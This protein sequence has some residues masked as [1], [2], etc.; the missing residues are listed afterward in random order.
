MARMKTFY[1][2]TLKKLNKAATEPS[3]KIPKYSTRDLNQ[4]H[5]QPPRVPV[6]KTLKSHT[7]LP[8]VTAHQ[9]LD[10]NELYQNRMKVRDYRVKSASV[11]TAGLAKK[12]KTKIKRNPY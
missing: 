2:K 11:R 1:D 10:K 7:G 4:Y 5:I 3:I 8:K 6:R 12:S 9:N